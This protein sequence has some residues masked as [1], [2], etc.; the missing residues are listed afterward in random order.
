MHPSDINELYNSHELIV[1]EASN[2]A[3]LVKINLST[4]KE[5]LHH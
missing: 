1:E 2:N 5:N 3:F 4:S